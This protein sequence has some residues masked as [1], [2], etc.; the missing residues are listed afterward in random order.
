MRKPTLFDVVRL[1]VDLPEEGLRAGSLG[2]IVLEFDQ[3]TEAYEVE[4]TDD[5]GHTV[6]TRALTPEQFEVV[7]RPPQP[8]EGA[9][10]ESAPTRPD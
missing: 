9:P 2:A 5:Q 1:T 8:P 7:E 4:F 10:A 6:A 3:P